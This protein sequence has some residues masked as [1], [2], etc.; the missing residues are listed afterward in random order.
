MIRLKTVKAFLLAIF[1]IP[2][3]AHLSGQQQVG[4]ISDYYSVVITGGISSW[5]YD[6]THERDKHLENALLALKS[7]LDQAFTSVINE[8]SLKSLIDLYNPE[9]LYI[10]GVVIETE[11]GKEVSRKA[12][13]NQYRN[14]SKNGLFFVGHEQRIADTSFK[15]IVNLVVTD[16]IKQADLDAILDKQIEVIQKTSQLMQMLY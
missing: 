12:H 13:F 3:E 6:E 16:R 2:L 5:D 8:R 4:F 11:R 1:L 15:L 10:D 7:E 14:A 9:A